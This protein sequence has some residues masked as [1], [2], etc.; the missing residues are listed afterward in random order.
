MVFAISFVVMFLDICKV[1][2]AR[3]YQMVHKSG[4]KMQEGKESVVPDIRCSGSSTN[5]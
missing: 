4:L 3:N 1:E 2:I 5:R